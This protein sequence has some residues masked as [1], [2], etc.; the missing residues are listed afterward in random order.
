MNNAHIT[1]TLPHPPKVLSPNSRAVWQAKLAP[2]RKARE[3]AMSAALR[4]L[5]SAGRTLEGLE[6]AAYSIVW[7][8]WHGV[9]PDADNSLA[10]CKAYLDGIAQVL[11]VNDR[12]LTCRSIERIKDRR[13]DM[14]IVLH[15]QRPEA[16][17][18]LWKGGE[19]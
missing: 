5:E 16:Q 13:A 2:R 19:A 8:Y 6:P 4:A 15:Y 11:H 17:L 1:I 9:E 18:P 7:R 12:T 10:S 3:I 14:D